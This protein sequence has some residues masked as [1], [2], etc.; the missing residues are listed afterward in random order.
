MSLF[1][2]TEAQVSGWL[3]DALG[4]RYDDDSC[5]IADMLP[6]IAFWLHDLDTA[7]DML[8]AMMPGPGYIAIRG[9]NDEK[10]ARIEEFASRHWG[11]DG[12]RR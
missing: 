12:T 5:G 3:K 1:I 2:F 8:D 11:E 7:L 10:V 4:H 9:T 6:Q